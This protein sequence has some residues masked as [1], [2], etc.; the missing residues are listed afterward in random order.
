MF[1]LI[2]I[3]KTVKKVNVDLSK[4]VTTLS[5]LLLIFQACTKSEL[6][7]E[8]V[9]KVLHLVCAKVTAVKGNPSVHLIYL[10]YI[11]I[12]IFPPPL[13]YWMNDNACVQ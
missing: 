3:R 1:S 11:Y 13:T 9:Q 2:V 7:C 5:A 4:N 10:I 8:L 6:H 12:Y